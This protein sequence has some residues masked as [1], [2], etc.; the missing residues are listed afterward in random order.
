MV[1]GLGVFWIACSS[2]RKTGSVLPVAWNSKD[3]LAG[4]RA[5]AYSDCLTCHRYAERVVGPS[6]LEIANRYQLDKKQVAKLSKKIIK[7]G[8]GSWGEIPM[9]PHPAMSKKMA[10]SI[11]KHI[12]SLKK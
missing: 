4:L 12:L 8:Y 5:L 3:S 7:G 10:E 1:L 2:S 11:V 6:Y 9:T